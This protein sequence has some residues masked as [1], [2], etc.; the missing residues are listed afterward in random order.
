MPDA[1]TALCRLVASLHDDRGNVTVEGLHS[2]PPY[3]IEVSEAEIRRFASVRPSVWLM[4]I[5]TL[6]HRLS[7]APG[8]GRP[9]H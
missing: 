6:A 8:R 5:G 1:L 2:G 3:D 4:G 7:G 9:R